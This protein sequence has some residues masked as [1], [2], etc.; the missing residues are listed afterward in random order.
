MPATVDDLLVHTPDLS[1]GS[2]QE[3]A[4]GLWL[5]MHPGGLGA[6]VRHPCGGAVVVV[7]LIVQLLAEFVGPTP[8]SF[9]ALAANALG[10]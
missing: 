5:W 3:P 9:S 10:M 6:G 1:V 4:L 2:M 7:L 8:Q